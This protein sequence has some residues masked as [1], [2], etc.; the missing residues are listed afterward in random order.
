MATLSLGRR[1]P[2]RALAIA[3]AFVLLVPATASAKQFTV[4]ATASPV[5]AA[6]STFADGCPIEA[7]NG[8][9]LYIAS[10][11]PGG[12]VQG[13]PNDIWRLTR[14]SVGAAWSLPENLGANVNSSAADLEAEL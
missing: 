11:R 3:V 5:A 8:L 14:E 4:W 6:N 1:M 13:D 7:P 12:T 10:N 2:R 9:E